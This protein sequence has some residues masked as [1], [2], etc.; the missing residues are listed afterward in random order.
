MKVYIAGKITGDPDYWDKFQ[1][2]AVKIRAEGHKVISPTCLPD[3][4]AQ[5][6]YMHIC[7]AMIDVAEAV[8]F[9]SDWKESGGAPDEH[10]YAHHVGKIVRYEDARAVVA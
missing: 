7:Y 4:L 8:Y 9:L 6:Q 2:A 3:G 10:R 1:R 5:D